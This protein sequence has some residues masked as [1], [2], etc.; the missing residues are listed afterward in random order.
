MNLVDGCGDGPFVPYNGAVG[1]GQKLD[2]RS[3]GVASCPM[4]VTT[5]YRAAR[6]WPMAVEARRKRTR[7]N[8]PMCSRYFR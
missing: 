6:F 7:R 2:C 3:F 5:R 1:D 4:L 8:P